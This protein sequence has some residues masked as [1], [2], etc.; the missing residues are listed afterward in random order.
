M[1]G[2]NVLREVTCWWSACLQD[3]ISYNIFCFVERYFLL[4]DIFYLGYVLKE[5]ISCSLRHLTGVHILH[6]GISYSIICI[7]EDTC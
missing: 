7:Q 2:G 4:D 1:V 5:G 3:G 6:K